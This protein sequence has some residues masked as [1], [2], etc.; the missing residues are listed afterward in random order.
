MCGI[1]GS[2]DRDIYLTLQKLNKTRGSK[3]TSNFLLMDDGFEIHKIP[4]TARNY[5]FPRKKINFYLG[6]NQAPTSSVRTFNPIT[7][8]PFVF[9]NWIVA[10]NGVLTNFKE[11]NE[12][13]ADGDWN[14]PVDSSII[15]FI[16]RVF[17]EMTESNTK[18]DAI[19]HALSVLEGTFGLWIFNTETQNTYLAK[20]G[21]TL[22][23]D[24]ID[25]IFS[26]VRDKKKTLE[27]LEDGTLYQLTK[28]GI[29][30]VGMFDCDSPFYV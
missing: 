14:N 30:V 22:F 2:S 9:D 1:Y 21:V 23:A 11:L 25:N 19:I 5:K 20:C 28:E 26:S 10:H 7:S 6:H 27:S 29:T 3:V 12:Q 8:H 24:R 18:E 13:F 4:K 15:P 16:I 17:E